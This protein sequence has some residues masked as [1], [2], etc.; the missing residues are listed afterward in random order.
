MKKIGSDRFFTMKYIYEILYGHYGCNADNVIEYLESKSINELKNIL[1][2]LDDDDDIDEDGINK[3]LKNFIIWEDEH[4]TKIEL[5][6]N[7]L[8][9]GDYDN[10]V[11]IVQF[12]NSLNIDDRDYYCII[13]DI[14]EEF[15]RWRSK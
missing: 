8:D 3:A 1:S 4:I 15:E 9:Y 12:L 11:E 6:E 5:L 7:M 14:C 13:D 2:Q 10:I